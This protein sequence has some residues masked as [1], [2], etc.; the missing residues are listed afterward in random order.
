MQEVTR[1]RSSLSHKIWDAYHTVYYDCYNVSLAQTLPLAIYYAWLTVVASPTIE[2]QWGGLSCRNRL[3]SEAARD[4]ILL[5]HF[6]VDK[7][8]VSITG[9]IEAAIKECIQKNGYI[10]CRVDN[11]YHEPF[12]EFYLK[13]HRHGHKM[14]IIDWDDT[15]AYGID[16]IGI[17]TL[18]LKFPRAYFLESVRSNLFHAYEKE[19]TLYY[20]TLGER[21]N[22]ARAAG[23]IQRQ[24]REA[25]E[26]YI[27]N[28]Q[29]L[30]AHLERY[31]QQFHSDMEEQDSIRVYAQIYN[32]Y[33]T[34]LMIE[35]SYMA[36]SEAYDYH[37]PVWLD[38]SP[39]A[40][41]LIEQLKVL[42][43]S[44]R[45]FKMLCS[46]QMSGHHRLENQLLATLRKIIDLEIETTARM[47]RNG[48]VEHQAY[49]ANGDMRV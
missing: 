6:G 26:A 30:T 16:S 41:V 4:L 13:Q 48:P 2:A 8:L 23:H 47:Q 11:Y 40:T 49:G 36:L 31:Y 32:S 27:Q 43:K 10:V 15:Y 22:E 3:D 19:D 34:A 25:I 21:F 29:T 39:V 18:I 9:D 46:S 37:P 14:T 38:V 44:W 24:Q 5:Q 45:L 17:K 20:L 1:H 33:T 28:R 42:T 35:T 7:H 12:Q